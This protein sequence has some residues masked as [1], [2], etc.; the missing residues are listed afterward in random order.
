L[1]NHAT[2]NEVAT[3]LRWSEYQWHVAGDRDLAAF[4]AREPLEAYKPVRDA[5]REG[6]RIMFNT[7][8][9]DQTWLFFGESDRLV[10]YW[11]NTQ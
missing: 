6:R 1:A 7:T 2:R 11:F 8:E 5:I 9:W 3:A 4:L 10:G